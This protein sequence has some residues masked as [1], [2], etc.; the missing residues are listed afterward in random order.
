MRKLLKFLKAIK[1]AFEDLY[2]FFIT[3]IPGGLGY[4]LRY[5]YYRSKFKNCGINLKIDIGVSISGIENITIGD[6]VHIDKYT[7]ISS[8]QSLRGDIHRKQNKY[9]NGNQGEII[10][11]NNIHICQFCILVGYGGL[12]IGDN[13][14]LSSG[15]KI[16]SLTNTAY[17]PSNPKKIISI[18]PYDQAPFLISPIVLSNNVWLGLNSILMPGSTILKNSFVVS[19]SLVSKV[20]EENS[21]IAGQPAKRIK[22]RFFIENKS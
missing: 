8:G 3:N 7:I 19:N 13:C 4:K 17:D 9:F 22:D 16:Y 20:F 2:I 1:G 15:C 6:N 11:G 21:Y 14:V 12:S 5:Y 18:M 10:I